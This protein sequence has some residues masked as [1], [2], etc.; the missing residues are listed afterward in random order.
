MEETPCCGVCRHLSERPAAE[1]EA[2]RDLRWR[3]ACRIACGDR[4]A[5]L[6]EASPVCRI[7]R[8]RSCELPLNDS[9]ISRYQST[10]EWR[11]GAVW[12][13]DDRSAC[14]TLL[15]GA[16]ISEARVGPGDEIWVGD[17]R[18]TVSEQR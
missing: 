13:I 2:D 9:K 18:I 10:L 6:S 16:R 15:N 1:A 4:I 12:V 3:S 5:V 8:S 11:D 7:G 17:S 14:G